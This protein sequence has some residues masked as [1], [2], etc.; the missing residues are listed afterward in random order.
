MLGSVFP[1]VAGFIDQSTEHE[2]IAPMKRFYT[3]YKEIV[4]DV[5]EDIK[6]RVWGEEELEILE[7]GKTVQ[8]DV[9]RDV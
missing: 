2:K 8:K 1:F 3:G 7:K 6:Q 5:T 9:K 4:F